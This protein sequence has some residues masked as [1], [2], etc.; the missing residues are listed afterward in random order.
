MED[1]EVM[2]GVDC[3]ELLPFFRVSKRGVSLLEDRRRLCCLIKDDGR[4]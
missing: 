1:K 4:M 3:G 2:L